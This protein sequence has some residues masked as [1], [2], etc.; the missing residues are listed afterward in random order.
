MNTTHGSRAFS[1]LTDARP[2]DY[3]P[4]AW[5]DSLIQT[6]VD[7]RSDAGTFNGR[8]WPR[9]MVSAAIR[10][11]GRRRAIVLADAEVQP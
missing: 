11:M 5:P 2:C 9:A 6:V 8:A 1:S 3:S 4:G 7:G 10:E